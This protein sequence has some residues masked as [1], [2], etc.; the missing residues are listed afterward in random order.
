MAPVRGRCLADDHVCLVVG[1]GKEQMQQGRLLR[2]KPIIFVWN[3]TRPMEEALKHAACHFGIFFDYA[4]FQLST[5]S[6]PCS[7]LET[8]D[9]LAPG[10]LEVG[11][12]I[13]ATADSPGAH[14]PGDEFMVGARISTEWL[15]KRQSDNLGNGGGGC[16]SSVDGDSDVDS[17]EEE[18]RPLPARLRTKW[19]DGLVV[20]MKR[21]IMHG[22]KL[23]LKYLVYYDDEEEHY[24]NPER[25]KYTILSLPGEGF[26]GEWR[27]ESAEYAIVARME[28]GGNSLPWSTQG[29]AALTQPQLVQSRKRIATASPAGEQGCSTNAT[30]SWTAVRRVQPKITAAYTAGQRP[31]QTADEPLPEP[32]RRGVARPAQPQPRAPD[33]AQQSPIRD[34]RPA[35][36]ASPRLGVLGQGLRGDGSASACRVPSSTSNHTE[37]PAETNGGLSLASSSAPSHMAG[38]TGDAAGAASRPSPVPAEFGR[39]TPHQAAGIAAPGQPASHDAAE[40]LKVID[41]F[42]DWT[43]VISNVPSVVTSRGMAETLRE[44]GVIS[45]I[46]SE[47]ESEGTNRW[48]VQ[49]EAHLYAQRAFNRLGYSREPVCWCVYYGAA[50]QLCKRV[51][52]EPHIYY[53]EP[54]SRSALR[55]KYS[56]RPSA[57]GGELT[58]ACG[59][60]QA[61]GQELDS[62]RRPRAHVPH[63]PL[64]GAL[65]PPLPQ[66]P[67]M[68]ALPLSSDAHE[69][70]V[71]LPPVLAAPPA[72]PTAAFPSSS[73][74]HQAFAYPPPVLAP[75]PAWCPSSTAAPPPASA[76]HERA[77]RPPPI[78]APPPEQ[79][80]EA[81]EHPVSVERVRSSTPSPLPWSTSPR[82]GPKTKL[83]IMGIAMSVTKKELKIA[84]ENYGRLVDCNLIYRNGKSNGS[85]Y[86]Q[87]ADPADAAF[88]LNLASKTNFM[89]KWNI[90]RHS[91]DLP[92]DKLE[93]KPR[94]VWHQHQPSPPKVPTDSRSR[95]ERAQPWARQ[96][97]QA[98]PA[99][100]PSATTAPAT[101][102]PPACQPAGAHSD[103][104]PS[105]L[106][107]SSQPIDAPS[108]HSVDDTNDRSRSP[109][110]LGKRSRSPPR[111]EWRTCNRYFPPGDRRRRIPDRARDRRSPDRG[112]RRS[113]SRDRGFDK[114]AD[115]HS[116]GP[117]DRSRSPGRRDARD[118]REEQGSSYSRDRGSSANGSS[119]GARRGRSRSP[120]QEG[121]GGIRREQGGSYSRERGEQGSSYSRERGEQVGGYSHARGE[122]GGSYSRGSSGEVNGPARQRDRSRSQFDVNPHDAQSQHAE[123][124]G[125]AYFG[126]DMARDDAVNHPQGHCYGCAHGELAQPS[127]CASQ[128]A[129][130][131]A[132]FGGAGAMPR[133]IIQA[134]QSDHG[135]AEVQPARALQDA[136]LPQLAPQAMCTSPLD[137]F[138]AASGYCFTAPP[139]SFPPLQPRAVTPSSNPISLLDARSAADPRLAAFAHAP[140]PSGPGFAERFTPVPSSDPRLA[141]AASPVASQPSLSWHPTQAAGLFPGD[142]RPTPPVRSFTPPPGGVPLGN[143]NGVPPDT[144]L[145]SSTAD[146][147]PVQ[148][149]LAPAQAA[150]PAATAL[151]ES[152]V[153]RASN[154]GEHAPKP[155]RGLMQALVKRGH[156]S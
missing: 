78:L 75:P 110:S 152:N 123:G 142:P 14:D 153:A 72:I 135:V 104:Q 93:S 122:Q 102:C 43:L 146:A 151:P 16:S 134:Y 22:D 5:D 17:D 54:A 97:G 107:T 41:A 90:Y 94:I 40:I 29:S 117:P 89:Q 98:A 52:S 91:S 51:Q 49:F 3:R 59:P 150:S 129:A 77:M 48:Y 62:P 125:I 84:F 99:P 87:Y 67:S 126:A 139:T 69:R 64:P 18:E 42:P 4:C 112:R 13:S 1:A 24:I 26:G 45:N 136:Q 105:S 148:N 144:R 12:I 116:R 6:Q 147:M 106:D 96:R 101:L 132:A 155:K 103:A 82:H 11:L 35:A 56:G 128:Q 124:N 119:S 7:P 23:G 86:V 81:A 156:L 10:E 36:A 138:L 47:K 2:R 70:A 109:Q 38:D 65:A 88:V 100:E 30:T 95:R 37:G 44:F 15:G 114:R 55:Q 111:L 127:A 53:L 137:P 71:L 20:E 63:V 108:V 9:G 149:S 140:A 85:G 32:S 154:V 118:R 131:A 58:G 141:R 57:S 133:L 68:A 46:I 83:Y 120:R 50:D 92:T 8:L 33:P 115:A 121:A 27:R 31:T 145:Q 66:P 60:Q 61:G 28:E 130:S 80:D 34:A 25:L 113:R 79:P 143:T 19:H 73:A 76:A 21:E 39:P 74:Q